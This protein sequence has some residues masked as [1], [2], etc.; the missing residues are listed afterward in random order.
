[1]LIG[2]PAS[3]VEAARASNLADDPSRCFLIDPKA[4]IDARR[5]ARRRGLAVV[6]FY[7]SHPRSEPLPSATD[8]A[9][10]SYPGHWYLIVRPLETTCEARLF[11][12]EN[13]AFLELSVEVSVEVS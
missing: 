2:T 11:K 3:I 1:M 12:L 13:S 10:A 9:G 5:D 8:L 7:H 6:G 4:H